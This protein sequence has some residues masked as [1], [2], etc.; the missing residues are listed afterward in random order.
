M[1]GLIDCLQ[2]LPTFFHQ[3]HY[4]YSTTNTLAGSTV[5]IHRDL[6]FMH[7]SYFTKQI[8]YSLFWDSWVGDTLD[9]I[10]IVGNYTPQWEIHHSDK[11]SFELIARLNV[12]LM[13]MTDGFPSADLFCRRQGFFSPLSQHIL[14]T[15]NLSLVHFSYMYFEQ[16]FN[17]NFNS[18]L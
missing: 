10:R 18:L 11:R 3:R 4:N 5:F 17:F 2:S 8:F 12:L 6:H 9:C 15:S 7:H 1:I 14:K 13:H 16:L